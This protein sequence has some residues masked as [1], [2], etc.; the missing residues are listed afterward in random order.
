MQIIG[1][2]FAVV[3]YALMQQA[4][5]WELDQP[6]P[7]MLAALESNMR[8]PLPFFSLVT[9]PIVAAFFYSFLSY[10]LFPSVISFF[11]I[12][13]LCYAFANG[14]VIMLILISQ[15]VFYMAASTHVFIRKW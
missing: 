10:Q 3:F 2:S 11:I 14:I 15:W 12:S 9:T 13:V 1:F 6:I 4:Y 7:S 8:L 5:S